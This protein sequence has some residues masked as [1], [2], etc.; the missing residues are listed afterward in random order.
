MKST[1]LATQVLTFLIA[2]SFSGSL[3]HARLARADETPSD[4]VKD[5]GDQTKTTANKTT[6]KAKKTARDATGNK[7]V[8]KD[9]G[10]QISNTADDDATHPQNKDGRTADDSVK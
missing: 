9:A 8:A 3:L 7:N 6:R 5:A 10:D 4:Q 1:K 2:A